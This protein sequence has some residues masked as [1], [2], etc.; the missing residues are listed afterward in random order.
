M[1]ITKC[2]TCSKELS[3]RGKSNLCQKCRARVLMVDRWSP[4][5][6]TDVVLKHLDSKVTEWLK[7]EVTKNKSSL[8][9][10]ISSIIEDAYY[11]EIVSK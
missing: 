9:V 10:M 1:V 4:K 5:I 6:E 11:E 7:N 8:S 2:T 3:G